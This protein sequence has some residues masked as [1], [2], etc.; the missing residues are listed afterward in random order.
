MKLLQ[1]CEPLAAGVGRHVVSLV[2]GLAERGHDLHVLYSPLRADADL[3]E[4]LG[5]AAGAVAARGVPMTREPSMRDA[6]AIA[7]IGSYLRENGPSDIIH[8]HSSKA[9]ALA[10]MIAPLST[11]GVIYTPHAFATMATTEFSP[12]KIAVYRRIERLLAS[13]TNKVI[14]LGIA[15]FEHARNVIGIPES[16]LVIVPNS[17]TTDDFR[18]ESDLRQELHLGND[19]R[20]MGFVGRLE[21]QKG[22]DLAIRALAIVAA[23]IPAATLIIIGEGS[24]DASLREIAEA[25]GVA[26]RVH[27][28]GWRPARQYYHNFDVLLSPSRYDSF[29]MT[30]MEALYCG[31]PVVCTRVGAAHEVVRQGFN[32]LLVAPEDAAALA[33]AAIQLLQNSE[34]HRIM[35]TNARNGSDYLSPSEMLAEIEQVY[36]GRRVGSGRYAAPD[37]S[38]AQLN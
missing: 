35:S 18:F 5:T 30:P 9:G 17:L 33:A 1:V 4:A 3:V 22:A 23:A 14:C 21:S 7:A 6:G 12:R 26:G 15:E 2:H 11:A 13:I 38:A 10:R 20:I 8:A 29:A 16:R 28:L 19:A 34:M 37:V 31:V 36:F 27:W 24:Q 32:G 25:C